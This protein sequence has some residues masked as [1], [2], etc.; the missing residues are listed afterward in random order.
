MICVSHPVV[1]NKLQH[2]GL[3]EDYLRI[4]GGFIVFCGW[5]MLLGSDLRW[6]VRCWM[7]TSKSIFVYGCVSLL[8]ARWFDEDDHGGVREWFVRLFS[9]WGNL[10]L[11]CRLT[12]HVLERCRFS[13]HFGQ[14]CRIAGIVQW[15]CVVVARVSTML[16]GWRWWCTM[17][18]LCWTSHRL[19]LI[20]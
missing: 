15:R 6:K 5:L 16:G 2:E 19:L 3:V 20:V 17:C 14:R 10:D 8:F 11:W 9:Q 1:D 12:L 18:T 13:L 4:G 7:T